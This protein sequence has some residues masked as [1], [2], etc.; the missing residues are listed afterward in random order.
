MSRARAP[1]RLTRWQLLDVERDQ[2]E[3]G[4][5]DWYV[6]FACGAA[7]GSCNGH[8]CVL[9]TQDLNY[10]CDYQTDNDW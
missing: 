7:D 3:C 1:R 6:G 8:A 2:C 5:F 4:W 10:Y 9:T